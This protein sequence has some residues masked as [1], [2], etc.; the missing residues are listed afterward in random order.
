MLGLPEAERGK[1]ESFPRDFGGSTT[2]PIPDIKLL[3]SRTGNQQIAAICSHPV[4][5]TLL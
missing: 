1:E 3:T 5:S 4:Y 2:L